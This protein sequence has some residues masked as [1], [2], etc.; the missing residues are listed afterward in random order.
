MTSGP[1]GRGTSP[2]PRT[3]YAVS[4]PPDCRL[5]IALATA[6]SCQ[7]AGRRIVGRAWQQ[8]R[9]ASQSTL[10]TD[11]KSKMPTRN[12]SSFKYGA[13]VAAWFAPLAAVHEVK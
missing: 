12:V 10:S 3:A 2:K 4:T 9:T 5:L 6:R 7:H 1:R 11:A 13:S 8:S